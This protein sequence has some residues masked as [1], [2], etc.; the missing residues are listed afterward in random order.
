MHVTP[1]PVFARKGDNLT[2]TVPVTFAEAALGGQVRAEP[3]SHIGGS[4]AGLAVQAGATALGGVDGVVNAAGVM[5]R[6]PDRPSEK[7]AE[8]VHAA[9]V[10]A[11]E[12]SLA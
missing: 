3:G 6:A 11:V 8:A 9:R 2:V 12:Q 7:I 10:A 4:V 5:Q 1:H